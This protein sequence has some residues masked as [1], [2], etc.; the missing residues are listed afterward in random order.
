[1]LGGR[2]VPTA[3]FYVDSD[4][5][6]YVKS[7][8]FCVYSRVDEFLTLMFDSTGLQ[9]VGF[10]LK[11]FKHIFDTQLKPLFKLNDEQFI[12]LV[13]ALEA[14]CSNLGEKLF[15]TAERAKAYKA[16]LALAANDNVVLRQ[17]AA[18]A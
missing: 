14:V 1:M 4:C 11:G 2:Y 17:F 10:K 12:S 9:L 8:A 3:V 15:A 5:V 6:E 16:A 18:A 7:D 13:P